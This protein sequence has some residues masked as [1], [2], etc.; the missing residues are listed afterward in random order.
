MRRRPIA[1]RFW[2]KV[3]V[4]APSECWLWTGAT[5]P[6][7][8]GD[9]WAGKGKVKRAHRVAFELA[10]GGIPD[11]LHVCHSCDTRLCCNPSHLWLGTN[12]ENIADRDAKDRHARLSGE[13]HPC[14]KLTTAQVV[15]VFYEEG[16]YSAIGRKYSVDPATISNIK[17]RRNWATVTQGLIHGSP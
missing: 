3:A 8:Y 5:H 14:A 12:A 16:S 7:G 17:N 4:G 9:I 15:A 2:E 13:R 10:N 11:G 6:S 1:D